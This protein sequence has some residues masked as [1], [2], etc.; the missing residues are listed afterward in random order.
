MMKLQMNMQRCSI[1]RQAVQSTAA[2]RISVCGS[3]SSVSVAVA[4]PRNSVCGNSRVIAEAAVMDRMPSSSSGPDE[5]ASAA[6]PV[7][8]AKMSY[9]AQY[10]EIFSAPLNTKKVVPKPVKEAMKEVPGNQKVLLSDVHYLP[11][12][13]T[14]GPNRKWNV[15]DMA[16]AG[17]I[18]GIH[19]LACAAPFCFSPQMFG[20]FL[21]SYFVTGCLG[22]TLSYH[23]Q[24]SHKSF[25]TPKWLEYT[26]AYCGVLAVQGDPLEWA[27]SHR[28]HH[29]HTDTPLDPHSPFEGF[30]WSHLGWLMDNTVAGS[31][32][33]FS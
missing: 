14:L 27:S 11:K 17:V 3:R 18:G 25:Q 33:E 22:I 7:E 28:Y 9:S 6:L 19:L 21:A 8:W 1:A 30:W 29:L 2:P 5:A 12:R 32:G 4:S 31:C 23:R 26:L 24:L 16:Y 13:P 20:L 15:T 10:D